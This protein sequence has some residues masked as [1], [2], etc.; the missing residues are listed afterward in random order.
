MNK[1]L[2][3]V[4]AQISWNPSKWALFPFAKI[5]HLHHRCFISRCWLNSTISDRCALNWSRWKFTLKYA[6]LSNNTNHRCQRLQS[7]LQIFEIVEVGL[8]IWWACWH[9]VD[10]V[11]DGGLWMLA[12][13]SSVAAWSYWILYIITYCIC[14]LYIIN[15]LGRPT[16]WLKPVIHWPRKDN[17]CVAEI[18]LR[19]WKNTFFFSIE[20][21]GGPNWTLWWDKRSWSRVLGRASSCCNMRWRQWWMA[22]QR[23]SGSHH[24]VCVFTLPSIK[25]SVV[26]CF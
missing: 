14:V 12:D 1:K 17:H 2:L 23:T 9:S 8:G 5:I 4:R 25:C 20:T 11:V 3:S 16:L 13:S 10:Q 26:C 7:C 21:S 6:V 15:S 24:S 18:L 22:W 19:L